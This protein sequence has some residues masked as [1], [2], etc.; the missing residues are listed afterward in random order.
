MRTHGSHGPSG[1]DSNEWRQILTH[2]GQQSIEISKTKAKI[3][4]KLATEELNPE[5]TEP[6]NACRLITLDKN[7]GVRPISIEEV[8]RRIMGRTITKCLKNLNARF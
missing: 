3:A 5:I 2:L 1:F 6:Y 4:R 7:P 8:M